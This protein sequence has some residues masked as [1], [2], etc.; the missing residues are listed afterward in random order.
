MEIFDNYASLLRLNYLK[1]Y[2]IWFVPLIMIVVIILSFVIDSYDN[3][4][5]YYIFS[6]DYYNVT[7][8]IENSDD[9]IG[10]DY[11]MIRH[12]KYYFTINQI[13][14]VFDENG[15]IVQNIQ[16]SIKG[17]EQRQ[18]NQTGTMVFCY[19]K[20]KIIKKVIKILF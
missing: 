11:I 4:S 20:E 7:V 6:N 17:L 16:L 5:F 2:L 1:Y 12:K 19:N 18:D 15:R 13:S 3:L 14:T 9:V 10:A 8:P